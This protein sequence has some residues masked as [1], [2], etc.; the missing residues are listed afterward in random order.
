MKHTWRSTL[1]DRQTFPKGQGRQY[2]LCQPNVGFSSESWPIA[3]LLS[4]LTPELRIQ[5]VE[6]QH[7]GSTNVAAV[8]AY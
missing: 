7:M 4:S 2:W 8:R 5:A 3:A 6:R 1:V